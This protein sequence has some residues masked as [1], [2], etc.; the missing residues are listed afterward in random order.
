MLKIAFTHN[1]KTSDSEIEA[2]F[3]TPETVNALATALR[4]LGHDVHLVEVSGPPSRVI[5]R[6][7]ALHPDLVFNT[8]EGH[9]GRYREAFYPAV[10]EQLSLPFT[11]SDAYVCTLTL[12]K[13]MTKRVLRD[14]GIPT[15]RSVLLQS[16]RRLKRLDLRF[17][18]ILKPNFEGSS[19]GITQESVVEN[20]EAFQ[21]RLK[22]LL[23]KY[24]AGVL[25]EE[26]IE[27]RDVT[28]PFIEGLA[29]D[30][31]G[32]LKPVE[33]VFE[34]KA[35]ARRK[36]N[37]YD[38]ELKNSESNSVNVRC[39]AELDEDTAKE[40]QQLSAKIVRILGIR[41]FGR[42]D[43]RV[44]PSGQVYFIEVNALPSLEPGAG[45]Y[46]AAE[47]EG[48]E[49]VE[50]TLATILKNTLKRYGL[51]KRAVH[52]RKS[53]KLIRVGLTYNLKRITPGDDYTTDQEAE[54]DS[55]KTIEAIRT[56][57]TE[58]GHEVVELEA[59]SDLPVR[60]GSTELDLVFNIAEGFKGRN[61]EAQVPAL[62]E[63]LDIPY[64]GSDSATLALAL[65]KGLAKRVVRA[66]GIET[67]RGQ[68]FLSGKE[69]LD[70]E[71]HFPLIVKPV[72]EGS[73]KGVLSSS[74]VTNEAELRE[75]VLRL[76]N[77]YKQGALVE[78]FLPG[79]E[80]TVALIGERRP[81]VLPP[82]EIVYHASKNPYPIYSYEHK[83]DPRGEI[84]NRVPADLTDA[85]R[86][87]VEQVA[88]GA[89]VALGCRDFA[90]ID[91][92]FNSAGQPCFIECNP[93]PGL[94]PKWSDLCLISEAVGMD[95]TT[96]IAE[97]IS[98]AIR[99]WREKRR[100]DNA[101][102]GGPSF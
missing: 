30:F 34:E 75:R 3:D 72:A 57:L 48:L 12:D 91:I 21:L 52:P 13:D 93:L 102:S 22:E 1:L 92:R 20:E 6:L 51:D 15:P 23:K 10:F 16:A 69:K 58:L 62:L 100:L 50:K 33:Y 82:M 95:Y 31:E 55:P 99:R 11:G 27:G 83:L 67:A 59:T 46:L 60:L 74:V 28:V 4:S 86:K 78:E 101:S 49:S 68:L 38:Y 71:L 9:A 41:D 14:S 64:S 40:L 61:R 53:R 7:E 19:K 8:S 84:E 36:Y 44:T 63:L 90:R 87:D 45:L 24:P 5:A 35:L 98:P 89:F 77:R 2:E 88:R 54:Y 76:L 96:L 42:M 70:K 94:T 85:L 66:S 37:I 32:V 29:T 25:V 26:F 17:P 39:P 43:F 47:R 80:F 18:L 65:D 81:K 79:R 73:S 56:A 97:L